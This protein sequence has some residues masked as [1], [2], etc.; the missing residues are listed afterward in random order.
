MKSLRCIFLVVI[1][2]LLNLSESFKVTSDGPDGLSGAFDL[3]DG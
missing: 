2:R 1:L 3:T